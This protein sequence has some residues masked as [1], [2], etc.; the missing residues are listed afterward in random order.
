MYCFKALCD[1]PKKVTNLILLHTTNVKDRNCEYLHTR[2]KTIHLN[3]QTHDHN[4]KDKATI[5]IPFPAGVSIHT[6]WS[7]YVSIMDKTKTLESP[8]SAPEIKR[9]TV[10]DKSVTILQSISSIRGNWNK[11]NSWIQQRNR[12]NSN[13]QQA[14]LRDAIRQ[15]LIGRISVDDVRAKHELRSNLKALNIIRGRQEHGNLHFFE[16]KL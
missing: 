13:R 5:M 9:W 7:N 2:N 1:S 4:S 11:L 6:R 15:K 8:N 10:K 12:H 3:T 14:A 16:R